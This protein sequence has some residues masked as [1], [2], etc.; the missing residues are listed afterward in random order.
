MCEIQNSLTAIRRPKLLL[1][2]ASLGLAD[3]HRS[4]WLKRLAP[5]ETAPERVLPLLLQSEEALEA[6]RQR[7]DA[8]YSVA[9]H[10]EVMIAVLA[11][12]RLWRALPAR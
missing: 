8:C 4:R 2:A 1:R 7:G 9:R 12:A 3:Y 5:G 6:T 11:E 10:L